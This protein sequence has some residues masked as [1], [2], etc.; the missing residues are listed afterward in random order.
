MGS[1]RVDEWLRGNERTPTD[2][3]PPQF[4]VAGGTFLPLGTGSPERIL[5]SHFTPDVFKKIMDSASVSA[6]TV[7]RFAGMAAFTVFPGRHEDRLG[8]T[9]DATGRHSWRGGLVHRPFRSRIQDQKAA[10]VLST[11][12]RVK[13]A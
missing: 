11:G 4:P 1:K 6:V 9:L 12:K 5:C 3:R 7:T 13:T 2:T 10:V 8:S